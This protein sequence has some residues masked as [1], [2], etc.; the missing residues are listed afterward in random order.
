MPALTVLMRPE[1]E[2]PTNCIGC[3]LCEQMANA[4]ANVA[5]ASDAMGFV[6]IKAVLDEIKAELPENG[7]AVTSVQREQ[8]INK[9]KQFHELINFIE[10]ESGKVAGSET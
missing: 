6:S 4:V 8:I 9:L 7:G 3:D 5:R 2:L 1:C 10:N